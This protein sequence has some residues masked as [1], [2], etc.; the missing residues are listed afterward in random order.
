MKIIA[1]FSLQYQSVGVHD[2]L[3]A[4]RAAAATAHSQ[5]AAA[6]V[7]LSKSFIGT[8]MTL[9]IWLS[10]VSFD[11]TGKKSGTGACK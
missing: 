8:Y 5:A 1:K 3:A 4:A 11:K 9:L 6:Q 7:W 10:F 2:N